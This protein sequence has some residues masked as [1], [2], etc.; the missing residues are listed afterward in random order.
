MILATSRWHHG[1]EVPR[2]V[3][4]GA[5][6]VEGLGAPRTKAGIEVSIYPARNK[7]KSQTRPQE[8]KS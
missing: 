8:E 4:D 5:G 7:I 1:M 6:Q 3:D 2:K